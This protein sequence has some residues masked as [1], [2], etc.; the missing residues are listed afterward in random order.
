[1][2]ETPTQLELKE[3]QARLQAIASRNTP[4]RPSAN[5]SMVEMFPNTATVP[6][7][8]VTTPQASSPSL[9][10]HQFQSHRVAAGGYG[11][12]APSPRT[13]IATSPTTSSRYAVI[14]PPSPN[15]SSP[16]PQPQAAQAIANELLQQLEA[17]AQHI[18]HL[19]A[20]QEAT[21]LELKAIAQR[22]ERDLQHADLRDNP[23]GQR[24]LST[25]CEYETS[26]VL[27]VEPDAAGGWVVTT[28]DV[29]LFKLE[30]EAEMMASTLRRRASSR[31]SYDWTHAVV[32]V[33][34]W[35]KQLTALIPQRRPASLRGN[36]P[37]VRAAAKAVTAQPP[38]SLPV[39][40]AWVVGATIARVVIDGLLASFPVLWV[41]AVMLVVTPAAIAAY[42]TTV[43]PETSM[44]W[45][46]RLFMIMV[47][48][49]LGGRF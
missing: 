5:A 10:I 27:H 15:S 16:A 3:I 33:Q 41:P 6:A 26:Q 36:R 12:V 40:A 14:N 25:I 23:L 9:Q 48:L 49:L 21:M 1:M 46:Y 47:G 35:L 38:M 42:R 39:A 13:A 31:H 19:S 4:A 34:H 37:T 18:N 24:D 45:G 30:R 7:S 43:A 32:S 20:E 8:R 29:D 22:L 11:T 2:K 17:K 28:R 44:I